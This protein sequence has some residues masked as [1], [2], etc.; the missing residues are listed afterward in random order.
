MTELICITC[1]KG[2]HLHVDE[3]NGYK[4]TGNGCERG[5][6]YGMKELI[7]PRRV[8]TSSVKITG[9]IYT[10]CS[11]K[12]DA[13]IPKGII[14]DAMALLKNVTLKSPVHVGDI[15][16]KDILGTGINFIVTREM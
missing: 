5:A 6:E 10:R 3:K 7:D 16:V 2:C 15:V 11:V 8:I 14:F 12:T 13:P 1:P 4:V 9:G